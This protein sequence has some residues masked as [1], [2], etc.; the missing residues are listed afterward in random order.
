MCHEAVSP[1]LLVGDSYDSLLL[2]AYG[3]SELPISQWGHM[4]SSGPGTMN[5]SAMDRFQVEHLIS[6]LEFSISHICHRSLLWPLPMWQN[7][8]ASSAR[9]EVKTITQSTQ[10]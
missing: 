3:K 5:R 10:N 2:L 7:R 6:D 4:I 8:E 9:P 1:A